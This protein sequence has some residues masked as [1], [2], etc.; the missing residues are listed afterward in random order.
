MVTVP[1]GNIVTAV[2][3]HSASGGTLVI[4]PAGAS[5]LP[6]IPL[7]A[8]A[9]WFQLDFDASLEELLPGTTLVFSG[10]D[11]Y[12]VATFASGGV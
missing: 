11:A 12:Y 4:T 1:P 8:A 10:T 3:T 5:A 7:P 9:S 2:R 6:S